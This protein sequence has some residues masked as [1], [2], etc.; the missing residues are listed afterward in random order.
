MELTQVSTWERD[1]VNL[2]CFV[3]RFVESFNII[4]E[5][6]T[7]RQ[8]ELVQGVI[9]ARLIIIGKRTRTREKNLFLFPTEREAIQ[10]RGRENIVETP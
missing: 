9:S 2:L 10:E 4:R 3:G 6:H 7:R 1:F 5:V 8:T